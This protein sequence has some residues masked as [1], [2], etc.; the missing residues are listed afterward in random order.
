MSMRFKKGPLKLSHSFS[1][2]YYWLAFSSPSK[3]IACSLNP[4]SSCR[5]LRSSCTYGYRRAAARSL[6]GNVLRVR[7]EAADYCDLPEY[8]V[9]NLDKR[10]T[11]NA[12]VLGAVGLPTAQMAVT[13]LSVLVPVK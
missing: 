8:R 12:L 13:Y 9:P 2:F 1:P 5:G 4:S 6:L 11:M 10:R 7:A 3:M